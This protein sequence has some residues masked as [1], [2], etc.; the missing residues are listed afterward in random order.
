MG[1]GLSQVYGL[2]KQSGG[3]VKIDSEPGEG[4]TVRLYLPRIPGGADEVAE[5]AP[6]QHIPSGRRS[7]VILVVEDDEDVRANTVEMLR[8]LG[9]GVLEAAE[10]RAALRVLESNPGVHLLFTDVG[11][12]SGLNGRQLADAA[13]QRHPR[14]K[15]LFTT[16]YARNAI[17]H[18]G[19]LDPGSR[20]HRQALHLCRAGGKDP[21]RPGERG[22]GEVTSRGRGDRP[23]G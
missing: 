3:H 18:H 21:Q 6:A 13:L 20:S 23:I 17:V 2:V 14:L 11:L 1:L 9:Y 22:I 7:E 12:P 4:T 5:V 10:G 8:E 15:L 16:G 19:R